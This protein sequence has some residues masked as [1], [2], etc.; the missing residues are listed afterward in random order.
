MCHQV[1]TDQ[2]QA[3]VSKLVNNL[4][5]IAG[6]FLLTSPNTIKLLNG[7]LRALLLVNTPAPV[8]LTTQLL[9]AL[10]ILKN[11]VDIAYESIKGRNELIISRLESNYTGQSTR[12]RRLRSTERKTFARAT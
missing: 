8:H 12:W 1:L 2:I 9:Q 7:D 3:T 5:K 4:T 6:S 10:T 11:R